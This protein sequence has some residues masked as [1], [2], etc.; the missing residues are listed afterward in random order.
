MRGAGAHA[1]RRLI[2]RQDLTGL[3]IGAIASPGGLTIA[4]TSAAGVEYDGSATPFLVDVASANVGRV[5]KRAS[6]IGM[7]LERGTDNR[8]KTIGAQDPRNP[9]TWQ[10][11]DGNCVRTAGQSDPNGTSLAYRLQEPSGATDYGPNARYT[12]STYTRLSA[13]IW[14]RQGALGSTY[15]INFQDNATPISLVSGTAV[16]S[17]WRRGSTVFAS[18]ALGTLVTIAPCQA[19]DLSAFGGLTQGARDVYVDCAQIESGPVSTFTPQTRAPENVSIPDATAWIASDGHFDFGCTW[20]P[21]ISYADMVAYGLANPRLW[22]YDALNYCEI[23]LVSQRLR[24]CIDG[25]LTAL[26][27]QIAAWNADDLIQFSPI[28]FGN[29]APSGTVTINGAVTDLGAGDSLGPIVTVP[30]V[31]LDVFCSGMTQ[32]LQGLI[33]GYEV[34]Q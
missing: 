30:G 31:G 19:G 7:R 15:Q 25:K 34:W 21:D 13:S 32:Q 33:C 22:T 5:G 11:Y 29:G 3:S 17:V 26:P 1:R 14:Y 28:R 6:H 9:N 23:N 24:V 18:H 8:L 20:A 27:N 16:D 12:E 4:R 10:F 2:T